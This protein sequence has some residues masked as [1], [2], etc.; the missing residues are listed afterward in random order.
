MSSLS[1]QSRFVALF[2][3]VRD[4]HRAHQK[5][6]ACQHTHAG[7]EYDEDIFALSDQCQCGNCRDQ[8]WGD[9]KDEDFVG[10]SN[11]R[12]IIHLLKVEYRHTEKAAV[13]SKACKKV[14]KM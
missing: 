5:D 3:G 6:E 11:P 1:F 12:T 10:S 14:P 7:L 4:S 9:I 8:A 2:E 13:A